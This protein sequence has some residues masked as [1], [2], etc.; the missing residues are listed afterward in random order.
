MANVYVTVTQANWGCGMSVSFEEYLDQIE[1]HLQPLDPM[2]RAEL[3]SELR[4]HL[5]DTVADLS[6]EDGEGEQQVQDAIARMGPPD[7]IG[8]A[9]VEADRP[10]SLR[11]ALLAMLPFAL[12]TL[13]GVVDFHTAY[14][15]RFAT[16]VLVL[17]VGVSYYFWPGARQTSWPVWS[18]SWAGFASMLPLA[19]TMAVSPGGSSS[20]VVT[21]LFPIMAF[22]F[23]RRQSLRHFV[24]ALSSVIW[25]GSFIVL[26]VSRFSFDLA[27]VGLIPMLAVTYIVRQQKA[28]SHSIMQI[29]Q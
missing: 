15:H 28:T 6:R 4:H 23:L 14:N 8:R 20:F 13:A 7:E 16:A 25:T 18:A 24:L 12:L 29:T 10:R 9:L 21:L 22:T 11:N 2:R 17:C 27:A 26:G 5:E 1:N 19:M 3:L